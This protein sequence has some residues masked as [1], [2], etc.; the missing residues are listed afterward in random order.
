[1]SQKAPTIAGPIG[2]VFPPTP[3]RKPRFLTIPKPEAGWPRKVQ[4]SAANSPFT[5]SAKDRLP[6]D[7][8]AHV[9]DPGGRVSES[10]ETPDAENPAMADKTACLVRQMGVENGPA[11]ASAGPAEAHFPAGEFIER[12]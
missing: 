3:D 6:P 4:N 9:T 12:C 11:K 10:K 7:S 8:A 2:R 1:M 5:A